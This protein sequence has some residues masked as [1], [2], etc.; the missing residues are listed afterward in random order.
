[1]YQYQQRL[2]IDHRQQLKA[3]PTQT[4][5]FSNAAKDVTS[6]NRKTSLLLQRKEPEVASALFRTW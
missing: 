3:R 5:R 1:M 4:Q 6:S 2:I